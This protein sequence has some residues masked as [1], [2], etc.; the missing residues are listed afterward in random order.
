M[1]RKQRKYWLISEKLQLTFQK[2]IDGVKVERV[3]EYKYIGTVLDNKLKFN[4][5]TDFISQ[6]MSAKNI[7]PSKANSS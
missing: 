7:L 2:I 4:K 1:Q 3:T 5:N 6:K